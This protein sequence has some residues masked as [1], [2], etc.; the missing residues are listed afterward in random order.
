MPPPSSHPTSDNTLRPLACLKN[1]V[2]TPKYLFW[3]PN[4]IDKNDNGRV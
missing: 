2:L 4:K 1:T 3:K